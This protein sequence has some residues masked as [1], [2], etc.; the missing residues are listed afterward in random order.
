V[1]VD[2]VQRER[3]ARRHGASKLEAPLG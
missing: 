3:I 1:V 2:E